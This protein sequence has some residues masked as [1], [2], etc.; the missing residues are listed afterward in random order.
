MANGKEQVQELMN[1]VNKLHECRV[2]IANL[3]AQILRLMQTKDLD[4][5]NLKRIENKHVLDIENQ[6][7][8]NGQPLV[9]D[10][11]VK[12][13]MVEDMIAQDKTGI[14]LVRKMVLT[15]KHINRKKRKQDI[16]QAQI[17]HLES[18]EKILVLQ[19][20]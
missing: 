9:R 10:V 13:A 17:D 8:T 20:T 5:L 4:N 16:L 19:A 11:H 15:S 6:K 2:E 14:A 1:I 18:K 3:S 12:R 7:Q